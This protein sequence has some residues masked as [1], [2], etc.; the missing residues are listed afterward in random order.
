MGFFFPE[1][2]QVSSKKELAIKEASKQGCRA[3]PLSKE[4]NRTPNMPPT[5]TDKPILYFLGEAPGEDE[6]IVGRQF[7]GRAGRRLRRELDEV[8]DPEILDT[9][10]WNN[11]VRCRP[12]S[13]NSNRT[14]TNF[15]IDCCKQSVIDDIEKT[16][17]C[18]VVGFGSVPLKTFIGGSTLGIWVNRFIPT[19]FGN[20]ACWY[21]VMYHPSFLERTS[22]QGEDT[23]Y[24]IYFRICL[25]N[26][27]HFIL[28]KYTP[29]K[30]ETDYFKGVKP[31]T[32]SE[33][34]E[35]MRSWTDRKYIA[36]DLE[37]DQLKPL[38][39]GAKILSVGLSDGDLHV[40]F[41]N[42]D[43]VVRELYKLIMSGPEFI[44][45]NLKFE[46]EWLY[47][48]F[49]TQDFFRKVR[50]H[51]TMAQAYILD[52]RT[53]KNHNEGM[54]KLEML[55]FLNF[56]FKLKSLTNIDRGNISKTSVKDL[57]IYNA[58]DAKYTYKLFLEQGRKLDKDLKI[59][60]NNLCESS[61]CLAMTE[62][63]GLLVDKNKLNEL[64]NKY[65]VELQDIMDEIK[66][67]GE[68]R[69]FEKDLG[70]TFNPLSTD[71]L[72]I[73][74]KDILKAPLVKL[75]ASKK[76]SMDDEVMS[77]LAPKYK[78]AEL[79]PRCR[80]LNKL[81]STYLDNIGY[82]LIGDKLYPNFNLMLTKTGRLS[83]GTD[84]GVEE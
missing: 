49:K 33:A 4:R 31:L 59:C 34:I 37:T 82:N 32:E 81:I 84:V 83:S 63:K 16:K 12:V 54:L 61:T 44:A 66:N 6:D 40:A 2:K 73:V 39:E 77:K 51:D 24:D 7:V 9:I 65:T 41:Q 29:P 23:E 21:Y 18:V 50:W 52:E 78:L 22:K 62:L 15:E 30:I 56:G 19:K 76:Y 43:K 3:C 79:I 45:H 11:T 14:P 71:H 80:E 72:I 26:L 36:L 75:T 35:L 69:K 38:R 10:R 42:S 17:P 68:I 46:I 8:F 13:G 20:H 47:T 55:T 53:T 74:F 27:K 28:K 58:L 25:E 1:K 60:Y 67:R 5:G 57:L 64:K 48:A 70:V